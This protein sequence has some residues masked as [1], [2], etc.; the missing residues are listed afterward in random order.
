MLLGLGLLA[1]WLGA[2]GGTVHPFAP[3]LLVGGVWLVVVG[4]TRPFLLLLLF[5]VVLLTRPHD[6]YPV[7]GRIQLA[8][9]CAA[10]ALALT[11]LSKLIQRDLSFADSPQ[12]RWFVA[13]S[14]AALLSALLSGDS[15]GAVASYKD[16]FLKIAILYVLILN[17]VDRPR[18]AVALQVTVAL[19]VAFLG[20]YAFKAR[21][22][23]TAVIEGSRAA[24]VG[25]LGDPNDLAL[26]LL[27]GVPF[28][29]LAWRDS[30]GLVRGAFGVMLFAILAGLVSTQSRGGF[31]GFGVAAYL[32]FRHKFRS[33]LVS[34][35]VMG[36]ALVGLVTVAG[37]KSRATVSQ[38]GI[39]ASAQGRLDAWKA[40][41]R[42][43]LAH[44]LLGVGFDRF[45][46]YYLSYAGDVWER[47][48]KETHNTFI[49]VAAEVGLLGFIPFMMLCGLSWREARR[50]AAARAPPGLWRAAREALPAT[51]AGVFTAAFF[52]SQSWGWFIYILMALVAAIGRIDRM[53]PAA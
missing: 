24:F 9:L 19:C 40:G 18:R 44:P 43:L 51:L 50:V 34:A 48:P 6:F 30:R 33:R 12:L 5:L 7:L 23:G 14:G 25:I 11:L 35:A 47:R 28:C 53:A 16:G 37:L 27:M 21:L 13:L 32:L 39:D 41:G 4:A 1:G 8:K 46:P 36:V 49:K 2:L 45:A 38:T 29:Y 17:L 22:T 52:L 3:V 26:A 42:M 15:A 10:G 20:L 31:M